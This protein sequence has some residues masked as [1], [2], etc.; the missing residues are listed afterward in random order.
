[1]N[2]PQL[3][4]RL[5][6]LVAATL[7]ALV[8]SAAP[9]SAATALPTPGAP[10]ATTVTTTSITI[11]W[12]PSAGPVASYTVQFIVGMSSWTNLATT[13]ATTYTHTGLT[14]DRVY[15]YRV[16]ASPTADSGYT[17]SAASGYTYVT[18]A[19]LPDSSPPT[20]PG[21]PFTTVVSTN[22]AT[23]HTSGSTDNNRVA[24]YWVQ[25]QVNG[26]W[27]DWASNSVSTIYLRDLQPATSYT[28]V[29]VAVDPNGNRS[30]RSAPLTFTTRATQPA[31]TCKVQLTNFYTGYI[32]TMTVEN[33]TAAT[34]LTGWT[35]TFTM[36]ASHTI[37]SSFGGAPVTRVG[38]LATATPTV[39]AA[40]INPG[41]SAQFGLIAS[42]PAG[43]GL[44]SGFT[45][46]GS[47]VAS[48]AC[49]T[50]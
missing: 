36:P 12:T 31:P 15:T 24:A 13:T 43:S 6:A 22:A 10:V 1:M 35:V 30:P 23:V 17:A 14:A 38:T 40:T 33:M 44:P 37:S 18:T 19:P 29:V 39:W 16:I 21:T 47:G 41:G 42:Y 3:S 11:T 8:L 4:R 49:A 48:A 5:A 20:T 50:A 45:L 2:V 46:N 26:V 7:G 28:V 34:T 25:R 9:A 32:L 27:T